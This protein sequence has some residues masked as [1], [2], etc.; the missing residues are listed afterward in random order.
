MLKATFY[1]QRTEGGSSSDDIVR[2][3]EDEHELIRIVYSSPEF[4]GK[5]GRKMYVSMTKA[6]DYLGDLMKSLTYDNQPFEFF[7]VSTAIHP[8]VLYHISDLETPEVRH[9]IQDMTEMT[10]RQSLVAT[11]A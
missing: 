4:G 1:I 6:I 2:M 7:Q 8:S 3:Y 9:I 11:N 10:L 5:K